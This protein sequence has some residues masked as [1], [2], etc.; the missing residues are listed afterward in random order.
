MDQKIGFA[1]STDN[2]RIAHALSGE[3]PPLVR[4]GTWLTH[5][6]HD[7]DSAIWKHWF[8]YQSTGHTLVRY[9]PRGCGLSEGE[10]SHVNFDGVVSD[11]EA[12]VDHLGLERFPLFGMSQG[13]AT[14]VEYV[15][16]HPEKVSCLVLYSGGAIG[17]DSADP[18]SAD[19]VKWNGMEALIRA[20]WGSDNPAIR[21]M[22]V[23]FFC[24]GRHA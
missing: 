9:D 13:V 7:W 10:A 1:R 17:W 23:N 2:L 8:E 20:E 15:A 12:V 22:F 16:R 4:V 3:G 11:L 5:L 18:D 24:P 14:A 21:S 6:H 19:F